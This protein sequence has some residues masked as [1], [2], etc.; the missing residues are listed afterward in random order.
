VARGLN[1]CSSSRPSSTPDLYIRLIR[2]Y[3][4]LHSRPFTKVIDW[5]LWGDRHFWRG[6]NGG[7]KGQLDVE[8]EL[9]RYLRRARQWPPYYALSRTKEM[10]KG[11]R[12]GHYFVTE[13]VALFPFHVPPLAIMPRNHRRRTQGLYLGM[14]MR[15]NMRQ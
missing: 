2:G 4:A 3:I 12:V 9:P 6:S 15:L 10:P 13:H 5:Y 1:L 14:L 7:T 11:A 8:L